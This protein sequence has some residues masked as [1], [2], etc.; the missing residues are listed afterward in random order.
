[1]MH[2]TF[3]W[4]K[5]VTILFDSWK[6]DSWTSYLLSLLACFL[7]SVFYQYME[8]RR[9]RFKL[10]SAKT[11]KSPS[12]S[13]DLNSPL[14]FSK[15]TSRGGKWASRFAGAILFGVD[16]AIGYL[17]MLAIMSFNAG[18]FIAVVVGL[19]IGYLVFRCGDEDVVVVVDNSCACS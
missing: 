7:V 11:Q 1:M 6:T 8:D 18:V 2:M 15:F 9:L 19:A 12:G 16:S 14:L 17:L 10:L 5:K 13:A 3:Y 4:G